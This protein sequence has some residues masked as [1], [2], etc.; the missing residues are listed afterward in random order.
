MTTFTRQETAAVALAWSRFW[1]AVPLKCV[2]RALGLKS[3]ADVVRML[4]AAR[5]TFDK[6]VANGTI[7][8][9]GVEV[10]RTL[11]YTP[12][13]VAR[14]GQLWRTRKRER[15]S[16]W[17]QADVEDVRASWASGVPQRVIA[18]RYGVTQGT[19]SRLIRGGR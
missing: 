5:P 1:R 15:P 4:G 8:G 14:I 9:P 13:A 6:C 10:G 17:S 7:P 18:K 12:E 3:V 19:V 16:R 11:L 2:K